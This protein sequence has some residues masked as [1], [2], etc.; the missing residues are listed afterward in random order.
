MES[1]LMKR[2][3]FIAVLAACVT[4]CVEGNNPV[5][6]V[7]AFPLKPDS[8]E[9]SD[10]ALIKGRLNFNAGSSYLIAFTLFSPLRADETTSGPAGFY[11]DE[12]V[13]SYETR[14][15]KV[16]LASESEPIYFVV[17]AGA[18]GDSSFIQLNLIGAEARKKLDNVVPTFPDVMTLMATV[19]LKGKLPSGKSVET[20]E[21]TY[22]IEVTRGNECP[23]GTVPATPADAPC[24]FP[25]QDAYFQNFFCRPTSGG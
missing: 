17:P 24:A 2:L 15:P 19:K 5:Q 3:W 20:N 18:D 11:A 9:L 23:A 8:C 25:G 14:N 13:L 16:T 1:T 12:I 6:L 22:P 10:V 7:N 4:G 21:V